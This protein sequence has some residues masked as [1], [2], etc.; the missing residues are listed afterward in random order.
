[1]ANNKETMCSRGMHTSGKE[2]RRR[3]SSERFFAHSTFS[4]FFVSQLSFA[5]SHLQPQSSDTSDTEHK[6]IK[7]QL[8][9]HS[10]DDGDQSFLS[11]TRAVSRQKIVRSHQ[12][13]LRNNFTGGS[14]AKFL[15]FRPGR[16]FVQ[17]E[18]KV[19]EQSPRPAKRKIPLS[20][21]R[22]HNFCAQFS[23]RFASRR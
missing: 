18:H 8:E 11:V 14:T 6:I 19:E 4:Y 2:S 16:T 13:L 7:R 22:N 23:R 3:E 12:F 1:M 20:S 5:G 15:C 17:D 9:E 21:L 10:S